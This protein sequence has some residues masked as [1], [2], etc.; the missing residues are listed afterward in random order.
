MDRVVRARI[1]LAEASALGVTI[2]DLIAEASSDAP[3]PPC[4]VPTVAEYVE[5]IGASFAKGTAATY[6]SYWRLVVDRL[7]ERPIGS[8]GVDGCE[9][10]SSTVSAETVTNWPARRV[11]SHVSLR[12]RTR[13]HRRSR[14]SIRRWAP[15]GQEGRPRR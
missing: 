1:L 4:T 8:V 7:G 11:S 14:S 10:V 12:S 5:T 6:K 13:L 15:R 2:D 9:A 3:G